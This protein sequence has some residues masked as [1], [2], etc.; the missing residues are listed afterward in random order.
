LNLL[1]VRLYPKYNAS[2]MESIIVMICAKDTMSIACIEDTWKK[3]KEMMSGN[4][5]DDK[6][7]LYAQQGD[8]GIRVCVI[9]WPWWGGVAYF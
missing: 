2:A 9:S 6:R 3:K 4:P 8:T 7:L 5:T 1:I